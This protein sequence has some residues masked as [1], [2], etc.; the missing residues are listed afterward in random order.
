MKSLSYGNGSHGARAR[1]KV[2]R[3]GIRQARPLR[4][5]R[6]GS[7]LGCGRSPRYGSPRCWAALAAA[8][9][10]T[11]GRAAQGEPAGE[12]EPIEVTVQ[13]RR[14]VPFES[15][16]DPSVASYVIRGEALREPGLSAAELLSRAPGVQAT[17]SGGATDL[18][19]AA[20]RGS[21][22]AQTP[23]YLAGVRLND[24]L[25][26]SVDLSTVPLWMLG[27]AEIYR[28]NAPDHADQLGLGGAVFFDPAPP[29]GERLGAGLERGSFGHRVSALALSAGGLHAGALLAYRR[30]AA[31]GDFEYL[32]DRGTRFDASDDRLLARRNADATSHD[33]WSIGRLALGSG[34]SLTTVLN[35]FAREAGLPGLLL[36]PAEHARS[37][38]GRVLGGI[39]A[40]VPCRQDDDAAR[41]PG[42]CELELASSA[43]VTRHRIADPLREL[44]LLATAVSNE[45]ERV[46]QRLRVVGS[47]AEWLELRLGGLQE[48]QLLRVARDQEPSLRARRELTRI[49]LGAR[50]HASPRVELVASS[51]LEC[52]STAAWGP[53]T[54]GGE[55][56]GDERVCG[57]LEPVG[58]L[59]A[60]VWVLGPLA[61]HAN[62]GRY[63]RVP[64]L[65]ELYGVSALVRGNP[66]LRAE[67][68]ETVDAGASL[69]LV[70][71]RAL[72]LYAQLFGFARFADELIAYR[73]SSLG[74]VRP[75][76][77][78]SA[79]VLGLELAAGASLFGT[80]RLGLSLTAQDPRDTSSDR[81]TPND[82]LP[83][84][85]RLQT[86][87]QV[88]LVR[89]SGW[90]VIGLE[91]ASWSA[92]YAYRSSRLADPAGL[93]VLPEQGE[94]DT[95]L[96]LRFARGIGLRGRLANVL[97]RR[98][99][100]LV[101]YPLPGRAAYATLE[102]TW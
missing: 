52:H 63:V 44:E 85:A 101:G 16:R 61:L 97:D 26:G 47:A 62:A 45:G 72:D 34:G 12:P 73:R 55:Q 65:G 17:R 74:A 93:V 20:V 49:E 92:T 5:P 35:A 32:D 100:D 8:L 4:Q 99:Y 38:L 58:R 28:G 50:A 13:G 9:A 87:P 14:G 22:S 41:G 18:A 81:V 29:R 79:R 48:L 31:R 40:R 102:A 24:D 83:L 15:E 67:R 11:P 95:E 75:Y 43:L 56:A 57:V 51:A 25:T 10:A 23:I 3:L 80:L 7:A 60:R 27:R 84:H 69:R 86:A 88:E 70:P 68:G 90:P 78:S 54:A 2:P 76:N 94:L 77:A 46:S 89:A 1:S 33:V 30:H 53:A 6:S 66:E 36:F 96:G 37:S 71:H 42:R 91:R 64:T 59:G 21:T 82:L 98:T 39:S 19:T